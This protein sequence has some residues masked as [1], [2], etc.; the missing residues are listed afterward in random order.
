MDEKELKTSPKQRFFIILIAVLMLGSVIASYAAI[1]VNGG[2]STSST[3]SGTISEAKIAEYEDDYKT[4]LAEFQTATKSDYDT[5][6]GYKKEVSA[7][8][9]A[10]AN[11]AGVQTRDLKIGSGR[12]LGESDGNY[13][14]YYIGFCP[15]ETIFDSSF[16]DN[17]N[18]TGFKAT[19]L[20][21]LTQMSLIEGW[22]IGMEGA[23]AGGVREITIPSELAYGS[24]EVD[25]CGGANKPLKFIVLVKD[26]DAEL[27]TMSDDL[28]LAFLKYQYAIYYGIDYDNISTS[29]Q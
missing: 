8:N 18:P 17:N 25:G 7:F 21:D 5:L 13:L 10:A 6:V 3:E 26:Y 9:E 16:D 15:N 28:Q 11:A 2:K 29:A 12:E 19:G 1:V 27:A 23:K 14:A 24:E 20:L 4:K 22:Y